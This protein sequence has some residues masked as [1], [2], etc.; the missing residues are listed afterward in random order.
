MEIVR[1]TFRNNIQHRGSGSVFSVKVVF[2]HVEFADGTQGWNQGHEIV[3]VGKNAGA[4]VDA[5]NHAEGSTAIDAATAWVNALHVA[6]RGGGPWRQQREVRGIPADGGQ[7][8]NHLVVEI[9]SSLRVFG[10]EQRC[11]GHHCDRLS[12]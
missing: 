2:K 7:L 1:A 8:S 4:S 3:T 10:V 11:V 6:L 9:G 5:R 12:R